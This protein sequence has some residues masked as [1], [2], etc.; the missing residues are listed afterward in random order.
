[1]GQTQVLRQRFYGQAMTLQW[2]LAG[3]DDRMLIL[4]KR[5]SLARARFFVNVV[6]FSLFYFFHYYWYA[7]FRASKT[8]TFRGQTYRYFYHKY[9][10]T[11]RNERAVEIPIIWELVLNHREKH[12][13]EVG[14]CLSHYFQVAHDIVDKYE[15]AEGVIHEDVVHYSPGKQ[16]DLIVSIS[17][18]EHVGYDETP[19][20]PL[21]SLRAV[22]RL[23]SLLSRGGK[24]VVTIPLGVNPYLDELLEKEKIAFTRRYCLKRVGAFNEWKQVRWRAIRGIR[25]GKE[26]PSALG[27]VIG[28]FKRH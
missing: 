24:L 5:I 13:L 2:R 11:W 23:C 22:E 14:N 28:I 3:Y 18:I 20:D 6:I 1:M 26:Y 4:A 9:N 15:V 17:T 8:F 16:Y 21:K 19:R 12:I 10:S 27:L 25:Y 7:V